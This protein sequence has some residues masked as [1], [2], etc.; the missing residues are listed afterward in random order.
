MDRHHAITLLVGGRSTE[1]DASLHG[2]QH[3]LQQLSEHPGRVIVDA[4]LYVDRDG[5]GHFFDQPPWPADEYDLQKRSAQPLVQAIARLLER[6][7]FVFSLL[8]GNEG[9]DGGWQGVADVLGVRGSFGPTLASAL[10]MDKYFQA[11]VV[12][13]L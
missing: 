6:N 9:E 11:M 10:G 2:Y 5:L 7:S 1:H 12:R 8:H 4:V 13:T 3:V